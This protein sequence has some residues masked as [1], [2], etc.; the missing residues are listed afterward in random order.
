MLFPSLVS[1]ICF[2]RGVELI[3]ANRASAFM[4]L[5]PI[6]AA[7]MAVLILQEAFQLYHLVGLVLVLGGIALAERYAVR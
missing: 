3:G 1:Q 5:V 7:V 6:F 4:N 2:V